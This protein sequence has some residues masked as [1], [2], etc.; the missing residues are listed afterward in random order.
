MRHWIL[1]FIIIFILGSTLLYAQ[2]N[3]EQYLQNIEGPKIEDFIKLIY[4][5]SHEDQLIA[6]NLLAKTGSKEDRVIEALLYC[7]QQGT[8]FIKR[9]AGTVINDFWDVRARSAEVL[10]DIGDPCALPQLHMVL[11]RDPDPIVRSCAAVA[12]G[13]IGQPESI[14]FLDRAIK[15]TDISGSNEVVILSCVNALGEIGD[16]DAFLPLYEV[17]RGR[18]KSHIKL[19]ARDAIEKLHWE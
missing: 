2:E 1:G 17:T 10:G 9:R 7:L 18:F 11:M 16:S 19:A 4:E 3:T 5:G 13:K 8:F 14:R 6:V 12:I 15:I